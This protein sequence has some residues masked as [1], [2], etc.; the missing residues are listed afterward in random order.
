[1]DAG[2]AEEAREASVGEGGVAGE[3]RL[4]QAVGVQWVCSGCAVGVQWVCSVRACAVPRL[5]L[6]CGLAMCTL[7]A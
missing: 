2:G 5:Y 7:R 1:M 6:G 4:P 3:Q